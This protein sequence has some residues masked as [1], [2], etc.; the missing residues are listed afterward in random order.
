MIVIGCDRSWN[1]V[2]AY[3]MFMVDSVVPGGD[4]TPPKVSRAPPFPTAEEEL[5][6][7]LLQGQALLSESPAVDS[8][9]GPETPPHRRPSGEHWLMWGVGVG[10]YM[11]I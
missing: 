1:V 7:F 5:D 8:D 2:D 6:S 9:W 11:Q 4:L 3:G 10:R